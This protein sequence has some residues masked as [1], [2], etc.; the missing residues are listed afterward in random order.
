MSLNFFHFKVILY[1]KISRNSIIV[2]N[3]FLR[4]NQNGKRDH[5]KLKTPS[6]ENERDRA[7][8]TVAPSL[9]PNARAG[10]AAREKQGHSGPW[11]TVGRQRRATHRRHPRDKHAG[12]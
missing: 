7:L 4:V 11:P 10:L 9:H 3:R 6:E 1:I 5:Q 8:G 2:H 12:R